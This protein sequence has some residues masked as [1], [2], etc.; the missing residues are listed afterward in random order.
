MAGGRLFEFGDE[1]YVE[2]GDAPIWNF[3]RHGILDEGFLT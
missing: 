3:L 1:G 2:F